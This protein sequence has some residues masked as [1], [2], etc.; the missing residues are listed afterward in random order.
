MVAGS[1]TQQNAC[2]HRRTRGSQK[3]HWRRSGRHEIADEA[4]LLEYCAHNRASMRVGV[5][6]LDA[7]KTWPVACDPAG[8]GLDFGAHAVHFLCSRRERNCIRV[9]LPSDLS[10][11]LPLIESE[12]APSCNSLVKFH[13][14]VTV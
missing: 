12:M 3:S 2:E 5:D 9:I 4:S 14:Q 1:V 13:Q 8:Q 10:I 6:E 11:R 7:E